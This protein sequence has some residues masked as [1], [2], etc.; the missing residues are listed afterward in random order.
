MRKIFGF[1]TYQVPSIWTD[2]NIGDLKFKDIDF[3]DSSWPYWNPKHHSNENEKVND[4]RFESVFD[5]IDASLLSD[6]VIWFRAEV[7]INDTNDDY[8]INIARGIDDVDQTYFNGILIGNESDWSME[9]NYK[10]PKNI[11]KR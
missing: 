7:M 4:G 5:E 8:H 2:F 1:Q 6:A 3:D 10:I 9:R 11:E